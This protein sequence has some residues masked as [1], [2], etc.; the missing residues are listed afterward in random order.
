MKGIK[1]RIAWALLLAPIFLAAPIIGFILWDS[2]GHWRT[3]S[4]TF[5]EYYYFPLAVLPLYLLIMYGAEL[6]LWVP[7]VLFI[8]GRGKKHENGNHNK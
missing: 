5:G 7:L 4:L 1:R 2:L 8:Q 6:V 3:T